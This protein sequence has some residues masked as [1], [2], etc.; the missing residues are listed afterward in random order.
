[1][2]EVAKLQQCIAEALKLLGQA[3]PSPTMARFSAKTCLSRHHASMQTGCGCLRLAKIEICLNSQA[4]RL[5]GLLAV[6]ALDIPRPCDV[7]SRSQCWVWFLSIW[8]GGL[9][10]ELPWE[11]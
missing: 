11:I 2:T 1:M 6:A 4:Q 5:Q 8:T 9:R 10:G 7:R 3:V